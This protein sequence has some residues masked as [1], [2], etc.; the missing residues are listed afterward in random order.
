MRTLRISSGQ[1]STATLNNYRTTIHTAAERT[2]IR[3]YID[4]YTTITTVVPAGE[5]LRYDHGDLEG[6]EI[7]VDDMG[8]VVIA[9]KAG[10]VSIRI[11][12]KDL[13]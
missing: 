11:R 12:E 8:N 7:I 3:V 10:P 4:S 6:L 5:R 13:Q 9:A 2:T 1:H